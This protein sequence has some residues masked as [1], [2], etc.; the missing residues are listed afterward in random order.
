MSRCCYDF[1]VA[2]GEPASRNV[3]GAGGGWAV[4]AMHTCRLL[5]GHEGR[6]GASIR[7]ASTTP[8]PEGSD[9]PGYQATVR[10]HLGLQVLYACAGDEVLWFVVGADGSIAARGAAPTGSG[11]ASHLCTDPL[12]RLL[13][14]A[15]YGA[16]SVSV[17][18]IARDDG[19]LGSATVYQQHGRGAHHGARGEWGEGPQYRQEAAHPH[20]VVVCGNQL[21]VADLGTN[22]VVCW[23]IDFERATL[24]LS[25]AITLHSL[26]GPRHIQFAGCGRLGFVLNELDNTIC[27]LRRDAQR[28]G[29]LALLQTLSSLPHGWAAAHADPRTYP[30]A[31]YSQPSHA[32]ELLIS[33]DEPIESGRCFV[34]C[35]NRGH[36]S[37]V[38]LA[39]NPVDW[40]LSPVQYQPTHGRV[41]WV[42]CMSEDGEFLVVQNNH[43]RASEAGPDS[44]V[45]FARDRK[46]GRLTAT[47][48]RLEF[49]TITSVWTLPQAKL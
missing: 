7:V 25:S 2:V 44:L 4:A 13:F 9:P 18:P 49:P 35:S 12:G 22:Q 47:G 48:A 37:I 1:C 42:F 19:A 32:S 21:Y 45:V 24:Q 46:S 5:V 27:V 30:N 43:T 33:P 11:R 20:G 36:D 6:R 3:T 23:S 14:T 17:L 8:L 40:T 38:V 16:G 31:V 15:N 28:G 41:P 26:A 39:V 29:Q 34:Y 10:L